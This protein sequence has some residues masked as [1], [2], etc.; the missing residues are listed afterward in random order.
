MVEKLKIIL[1][2][3]RFYAAILGAALTYINAILKILD[4]QQMLAVIAAISSW[5]IGESIRTSTPA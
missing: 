3:K 1:S 5:I 4:D 2:S